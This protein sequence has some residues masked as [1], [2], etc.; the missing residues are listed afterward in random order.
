[1]RLCI[2]QVSSRPQKV[3]PLYGR[4]MSDR[5]AETPTNDFMAEVSGGEENKLATIGKREMAQSPSHQITN[6]CLLVLLQC[7]TGHQNNQM[8][9]AE[10]FPVI[11]NQLKGICRRRSMAQVRRLIIIA[12][13]RSSN[14]R[15]MR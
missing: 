7:V 12:V 13:L 8:Q 9:A 2:I 15:S 6:L 3:S 14:R 10:R 1:M 11:L 4:S 5:A